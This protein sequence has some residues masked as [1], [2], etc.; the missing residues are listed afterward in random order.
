M[1]QTS[2]E[3]AVD[4]DKFPK[5]VVDVYVMVLQVCCLSFALFSAFLLLYKRFPPSQALF[6]DLCHPFPYSE[7]SALL[8]GWH[9]SPCVCIRTQCPSDIWLVVDVVAAD[10]LVTCTEN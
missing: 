2:L 7:T 8:L 1:L 3:A 4:V 6:T 9:C 10:Q 5:A